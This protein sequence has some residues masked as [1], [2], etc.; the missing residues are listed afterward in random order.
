MGVQEMGDFH[1]VALRGEV[2]RRA[3]VESADVGVRACFQEGGGHL[4]V[5]LLHGQVQGGVSA[6][7]NAIDVRAAG[8][9][10]GDRRRM[11]L[12][13]REV[14]RCRATVAGSVG[15]SSG[16]NQVSGDFRMTEIRCDVQGRVAVGEPRIGIFIPVE[17][18]GGK[19]GV[20]FLGREMQGR[21]RVEQSVEECGRV[22][23]RR[24]PR[25][26]EGGDIVLAY[27]RRVTAH[28][29]LDRAFDAVAVGAD[30]R[31][32]LQEL[33]ADILHRP[34][35]FRPIGRD[36]SAEQFEADEG[37]KVDLSRGGTDLGEVSLEGA[38][39]G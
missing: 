38:S 6:V 31:N 22:L 18:N 16:G 5:A 8:N 2:E 10:G 11:T 28:V 26:A 15:V 36:P 14:E 27:S 37:R 35:E 20:S 12:M 34:V 21:S 30:F 39:G 3:S 29:A 9:Q 25:S 32:A 17:E 7:A 4:R 19:C 1:V 33:P 23:G 13:G 24:A